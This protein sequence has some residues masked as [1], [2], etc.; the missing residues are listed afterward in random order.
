MHAPRY[1][2]SDKSSHLFRGE[3]GPPARLV[4]GPARAVHNRRT[5]QSTLGPAFHNALSRLQPRRE[6]IRPRILPTIRDWCQA[7]LFALAFETQPPVA[8]LARNDNLSAKWALATI[9]GMTAVS[10][11]PRRIAGCLTDA[12]IDPS[13][14]RGGWRHQPDFPPLARRIS[15]G[16]ITHSRVL[17]CRFCAM[18]QAAEFCSAG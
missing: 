13:P 2:R 10:Q 1:C 11:S 15:K 3:S 16:P 17:R 9:G 7:S 5:R 4:R 18:T 8:E 12:A 6:P 14:L